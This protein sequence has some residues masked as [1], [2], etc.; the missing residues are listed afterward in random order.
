MRVRVS[1]PPPILPCSSH[2]AIDGFIVHEPNQW[3]VSSTHG[4]PISM[5]PWLECG[6]G[7]CF[8]SSQIEG[9]T[10]FGSTILLCMSI[11]TTVRLRVRIQRVRFSGLDCYPNGQGTGITFWGLVGSTPP[12]HT[13]FD[14]MEWICEGAY[15]SCRET[16]RCERVGESL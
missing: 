3:W 5:G 14:F 15:S 12:I 9:S 6:K 11:V 8:A 10:P 7:I 4:I 2:A 13:T 1:P 16:A